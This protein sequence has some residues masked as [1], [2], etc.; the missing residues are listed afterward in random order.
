MRTHGDMFIIKYD[1]GS[2]RKV[3]VGGV[4]IEIAA[5]CNMDVR[6]NQDQIG[7]IHAAPEGHTFFKKGDKVFTHYLASH[8][9][10]SFEYEGEVY[11]RVPLRSIF[12][13]V[14]ED[15]TFDMKDKVYL[16]DEIVVEAPKSPSGILLT[17]FDD[18]RQELRLKVLNAPK[19]SR[20]IFEGDKIISKDDYQ[21]TLT[22][23]KRKYVKIDYEFILATYE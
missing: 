4:E 9:S 23:N 13:R 7:I 22:Y 15:E 11:H 21:Y 17:P 20:D 8:E 19:S 14:N 12:F 5:E 10:N 16:C 1:I 3:D 18:K 2:I 6:G